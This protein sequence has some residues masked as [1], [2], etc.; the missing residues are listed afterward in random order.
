MISPALLDV[1]LGLVKRA[2]SSLAV[3]LSLRI[4]D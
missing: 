4:E 3:Q 2:D 1:V